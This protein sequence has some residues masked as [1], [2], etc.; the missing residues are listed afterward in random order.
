MILRFER[1]FPQFESMVGDLSARFGYLL[2]NLNQQGFNTGT[3]FVLY[4]D[5]IPYSLLIPLHGKGEVLSNT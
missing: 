4:M 5:T 3:T 1:P 2:S